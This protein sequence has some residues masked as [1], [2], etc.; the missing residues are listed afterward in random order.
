MQYKSF[1]QRWSIRG[2]VLMKVFLYL[3]GLFYMHVLSD[4]GCRTDSHCA[5]S[6]PRE[7]LSGIEEVNVLKRWRPRDDSNV[8]P[9][10]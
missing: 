8:R 1:G 5:R 9:I 10:A 7:V 3:A 4:G 2:V 6:V